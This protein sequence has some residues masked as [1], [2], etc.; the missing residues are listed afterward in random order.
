VNITMYNLLNIRG[1][2]AVFQELIQRCILG[3]T[4]T[5]DSLSLR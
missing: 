4:L 5:I 1:P 2:S 3:I